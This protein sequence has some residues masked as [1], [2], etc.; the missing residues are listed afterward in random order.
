MKILKSVFLLFLMAVVSGSCFGASGNN[1]SS[2]G[3]P[4]VIVKKEGGNQHGRPSAPSNARIYFCYDSEN[5]EC[6][7]TLRDDIEYM[8][9]SLESLSTGQMYYGD[10][11]A[12]DPTMSVELPASNYYIM[13]VTDNGSVYE[14]EVVVP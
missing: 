8:S 7:F 4:Q 9:V 6:V 3:K 14:G 2:H 1:Q 12:T 5:R 11:D 10:V 13:C